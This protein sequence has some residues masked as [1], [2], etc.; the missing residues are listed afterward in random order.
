[1]S[2]MR[3]ER[4]SA[5]LFAAFI[6]SRTHRTTPPFPRADPALGGYVAGFVPV[7]MVIP[8]FASGVF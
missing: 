5:S 2:L 6:Y 7:G 1:M 3:E 8:L 4:P